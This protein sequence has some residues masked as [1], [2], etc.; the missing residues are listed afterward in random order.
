MRTVALVVWG[1]GG[2]GDGTGTD[3]CIL[4]TCN[5]SQMIR[6]LSSNGF[7]LCIHLFKLFEPRLQ[8]LHLKSGDDRP[9]LSV[10]PLDQHRLWVQ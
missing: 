4:E 1:E 9:R 2:L 10:L 8:F 3:L 6:I 7:R 5:S